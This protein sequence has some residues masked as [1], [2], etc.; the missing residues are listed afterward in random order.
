MDVTV[1]S[2]QPVGAGLGSSASF[3]VCLA[4]GLLTTVALISP[5]QPLN[6]ENTMATWSE[7]DKELINSWAF[8]GERIIHGKPSGIDN[9]MAT[10]GEE[11]NGRKDKKN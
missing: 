9:S 5:K 1:S 6:G 7:K 2:T 8:E 11:I 10:Y 4:A 3:S